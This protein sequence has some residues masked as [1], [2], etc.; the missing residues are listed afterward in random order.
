MTLRIIKWD[1]GTYSTSPVSW[2]AGG[3]CLG[4]A[5]VACGSLRQGKVVTSDGRSLTAA[6]A[7]RA[8]LDPITTSGASNAAWTS[9]ARGVFDRFVTRAPKAL[10]GRIEMGATTC[11]EKGCMVT[12]THARTS[13]VDKFTELFS[14]SEVFQRYPGGK[15]RTA[16]ELLPTGKTRTVWVLLPP[17]GDEMRE[18]LDARRP[19]S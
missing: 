18:P 13:S 7:T 17:D 6:E 11:Y 10:R 12:L 5:L 3:I 2:F 16:P 15:L 1:L 9:D 14:R 4:L 8:L 19:V